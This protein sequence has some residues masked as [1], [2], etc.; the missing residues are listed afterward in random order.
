MV[1]SGNTISLE[2]KKIAGKK[3]E[4]I[5]GVKC[6]KQKNE[7]KVRSFNHL[8][9]SKD[10]VRGISVYLIAINTPLLQIIGFFSHCT[11]F[12]HCFCWICGEMSEF[13]IPCHVA[14]LG[15][16]LPK[17]RVLSIVEQTMALVLVWQ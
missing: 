10:G 14:V 2:Q 12:I 7:Y 11:L 8:N 13:S 16:E 9:K 5:D 15:V 1:W 4:N 17:T 6:R 3:V